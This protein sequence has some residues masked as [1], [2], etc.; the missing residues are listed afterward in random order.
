MVTINRLD[1]VI[2]NPVPFWFS[3]ELAT[4][5]FKEIVHQQT[6]TCVTSN[7]AECL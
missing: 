1:D 3:A 7:K 5:L 6:S 4:N 2:A